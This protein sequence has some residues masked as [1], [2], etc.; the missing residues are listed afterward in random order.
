M[1]NIPKVNVSF[2][3]PRLNGKKASITGVI[4]YY[5]DPARGVPGSPDCAKVRG[6]GDQCV[7]EVGEI[8]K[9]DENERRHSIELRQAD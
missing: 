6:E 3:T 1:S 2:S 7:V 8:F 5:P 4:A 9:R